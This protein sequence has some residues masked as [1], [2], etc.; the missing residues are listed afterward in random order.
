MSEQITDDNWLCHDLDELKNKFCD[1][2]DNQNH[3]Q[4]LPMDTAVQSAIVDG[5]L[6]FKIYDVVLTNPMTQMNKTFM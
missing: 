4:F 5:K 3:E 1:W 2:L 6:H